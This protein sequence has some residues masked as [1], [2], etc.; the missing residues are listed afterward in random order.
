M[1]DASVDYD[2]DCHIGSDQTIEI[3]GYASWS[4]VLP[5]SS[6]LRAHSM[7]GTEMNSGHQYIIK[8]DCVREPRICE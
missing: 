2:D 3:R 4:H 6:P 5:G 7:Q 1:T 8:Y